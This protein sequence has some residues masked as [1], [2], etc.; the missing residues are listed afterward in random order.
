MTV[1]FREGQVGQAGDLL[2]EI[3]PRP[4]EVQLKQAEGQLRRD[5]ALLA[6][7]K[8]DLERYRVLLRQDA[9]PKQQLDTQVSLVRQD[10]AVVKVDE[11]RS[12][13]RSS[14]SPTAG[15][16]RRS[17]AASVCAWWTPAT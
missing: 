5:Q 2:A 1:A 17:R 13:T 4:F 15:S 8:V 3:D 7:A 12:R 10:E 16:P 6:N 14:S 9:I 11:A